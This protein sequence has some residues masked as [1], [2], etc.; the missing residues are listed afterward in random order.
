MIAYVTKQPAISAHANQ[1]KTRSALA[2][3]VLAMP[4]ANSAVPTTIR[5]A[6]AAASTRMVAT[7][8]I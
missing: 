5:T 6:R 7:L 2:G 1:T 4:R 3:T 8:W